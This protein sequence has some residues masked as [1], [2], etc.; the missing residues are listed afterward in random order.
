MADVISK[1]KPIQSKYAL[2]YVDDGLVAL[3]QNVSVTLNYQVERIATLESMASIPISRG[4]T[5]ALVS[6]RTLLLITDG[7]L[8]INSLNKDRTIKLV[9]KKNKD[10]KNPMIIELNTAKLTQATATYD[11][12]GVYVFRDVAFEGVTKVQNLSVLSNT[13][14][15][16]TL[17]NESNKKVVIGQEYFGVALGYIKNITYDVQRVTDLTGTHVVGFLRLA[18]YISI[19][20]RKLVLTSDFP[21]FEMNK[22]YELLTD[23]NKDYTYKITSANIVYDSEGLVVVENIQYEGVLDK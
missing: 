14:N 16:L 10:D 6:F 23:E 15:N 12:N 18:G 22:L 21:F 19:T 17:Q 3:A 20:I 1:F 11:A 2:L 8:E 13:N 7:G 5:T 9:L 4:P